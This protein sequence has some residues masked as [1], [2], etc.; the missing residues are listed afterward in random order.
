VELKAD[1]HALLK[2]NADPTGK[3][4]LGTFNNCSN[5]KTPWERT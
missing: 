5:G 3:K 2:T 4:V 1:G